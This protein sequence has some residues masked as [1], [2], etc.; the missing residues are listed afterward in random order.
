MTK[1]VLFVQSPIGVLTLVEADGALKELRFEE[2]AEPGETLQ[3][4]PL[5]K[6]AERELREYFEGKRKTFSVPMKPDGTAFQQAVWKA[7][8]EIPYGETASYGEVA[9]RIGNPKAARAVGM[10][11]HQNPLAIFYPC[12]RVIGAGGKMVGYGG[13][14]SVKEYLLSLET[15]AAR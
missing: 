12:H 3:A 4:T 13:G 15:N 6:Q 9:K 2:H 5:L 7:L 14:L 11:N 1:S 10:A 8:L